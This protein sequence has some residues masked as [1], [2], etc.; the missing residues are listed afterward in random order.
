MPMT[1]LRMKDAYCQILL[2]S[3]GKCDHFHGTKNRH[4]QLY[5]LHTFPSANRLSSTYIEQG[6]CYRWKK[7]IKD[8]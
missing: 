6:G 1:I 7:L 8:D 2:R 5:I 4:I 3:T